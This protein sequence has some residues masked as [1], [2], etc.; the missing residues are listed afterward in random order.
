M[1]TIGEL[2]DFGV[3]DPIDLLTRR[4]RSGRLAVKVGGQEVSLF[5]ERGALCHVASTDITL[6]LGR[7]LVRLS[8]IDPSGSSGCRL[9]RLA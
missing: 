3:V 1:V 8:G 2:N 4:E 6:R 9:R 7:M 5:F